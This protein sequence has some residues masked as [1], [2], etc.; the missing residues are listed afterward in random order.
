M[1]GAVLKEEER[2][3]RL[4]DPG[5]HCGGEGYSHPGGVFSEEAFERYYEKAD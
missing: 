3:R 1:V 4:R 5:R 2:N